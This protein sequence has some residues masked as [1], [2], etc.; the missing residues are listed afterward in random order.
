MNI[1]DF[2][3]NIGV[4]YDTLKN[5]EAADI[6]FRVAMKDH[7]VR[8]EI[9]VI[10]NYDSYTIRK[11][12]QEKNSFIKDLFAYYSFVDVIESCDF[13]EDKY[14]HPLYRFTIPAKQSDSKWVRQNYKRTYRYICKC[15]KCSNFVVL[16]RPFVEV[17]CDDCRNNPDLIKVPVFSF[18]KKI[19]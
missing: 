16:P 10:E 9:K 6:T 3:K 19:S 2:F 18:I 17:V 8:D 14:G 5:K 4:D 11:E 13:G 7:N 15:D 1:K 12:K